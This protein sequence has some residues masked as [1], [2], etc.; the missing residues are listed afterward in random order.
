MP[1][2]H[3]WPSLQTQCA[4]ASAP[5][6]G[7]S[8]KV[9]SGTTCDNRHGPTLTPCSWQHCKKAPNPACNSRVA[10]VKA[11]SGSSRR[12]ADRSSWSQ[13]SR[14][15]PTP[16]AAFGVELGDSTITTDLTGTGNS[17]SGPTATV[18]VV[19]S[20]VGRPAGGKGAGID[21]DA[22]GYDVDIMGGR[23]P[24]DDNLAE[25]LIGGQKLVPDPK[26]VAF[27]LSRQLDARPD[28]GVGE[29]KIAAGE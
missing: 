13:S 14:R 8:P 9:H 26:Q 21:I 22:I 25:I 23:M 7:C 29:E 2:F 19:G 3:G 11:P 6:V 4:M 17:A 20:P 27:D 18:A 24:V 1:T 10:P 12:R 15:L 16:G 5:Y 28:A